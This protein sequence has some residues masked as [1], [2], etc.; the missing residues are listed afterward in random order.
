MT[1]SEHQQIFAQ[2]VAQMIIFMYGQTN[3]KCTFGEAYRTPEQAALYAKEGKG[4]LK[5]LHCDRLAIDLNLFLDGKYLTNYNSYE[6]FG[7]YWE[8]MDKNNRWGGYF[9]SKYGGKIVDPG[10]FERKA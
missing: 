2:H 3:Y 1:L 6:H 4:I 7:A 5:S 8:G 9:V 10:H